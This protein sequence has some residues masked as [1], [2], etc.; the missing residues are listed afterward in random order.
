MSKAL[1]IQQEFQCEIWKY[2]APLYVSSPLVTLL[3]GKNLASCYGKGD[4]QLPAVEYLSCR[5]YYVSFCYRARRATRL[6]TV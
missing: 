1:L 5:C 6:S 3:L 2:L 4:T